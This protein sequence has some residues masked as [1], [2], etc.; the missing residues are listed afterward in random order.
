MVTGKVRG[1]HYIIYRLTRCSKGTVLMNFIYYFS[2]LKD[3][4]MEGG[5]QRQGD[6]PSTDWDK[7]EVRGWKC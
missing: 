1:C 4:Y 7:S 2:H 5:A 3:I 6:L